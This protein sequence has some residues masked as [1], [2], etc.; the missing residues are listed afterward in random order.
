MNRNVESEL[1]RWKKDDRRLP[2]LV[3]GA[4]QV[5]KTYT[6]GKFGREQFDDQLEVNFELEPRYGACF[7]DSLDPRRLLDNIG[8]ISGHVVVPGKTL[9]FLDEVQIC[10]RAIL[11]LR[12]FYEKLPDLHVIAAGSLLEFAM[13]Q[14]DFRMPVGRVQYLFMRPF[15]FG[16]FLDAVGQNQARQQVRACRLSEPLPP[17]LHQHLLSLVRTYLAVGGMPAAVSEYVASGSVIRCGKVQASIAQTYRDDFGK[18]ATRARVPHLQSVFG[19]IPRMVGRKFKYSAVDSSVQSRELKAALDLLERAGVVYRVRQTSGAGLPLEVEADDRNFKVVFLDVGLMQHLCGLSGEAL[20]IEDLL[21]I[22]SG[23]VAEQFVG[24]ELVASSEP[25]ERSVLHYWAREARTSNAEVDYLV[26]HGARVLPLEVKS[27][28][29]GSLR[30]MHLF[31]KQYD[32]P[33]GL[34]VAQHPHGYLPPVV[35]VPLYA[36]ER[37]KP[38]LS[39]ALDGAISQ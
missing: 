1:L 38:L 36:I 39:E 6:V 37:L 8:A 28:K 26:S 34:R 33:C 29:M 24:Q 9:L 27:G 2:L 16:E 22:H 13:A 35:S 15:S 21:S 5:G 19:A 14:E 3:R 18:Y 32:T 4:R 7:D 11:A 12:Y 31:L 30:S 25:F 17:V 23:A 10:P 20:M